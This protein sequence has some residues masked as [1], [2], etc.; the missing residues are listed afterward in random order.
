MLLPELCASPFDF[1]GDIIHSAA[2]CTESGEEC[3]RNLIRLN[4][5]VLAG[6]GSITA[7]LLTWLVF[8]ENIIH[9]CFLSLD[10]KTK[11]KDVLIPH[12]AYLNRRQSLH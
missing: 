1:S 8:A 10:C 3:R 7:N 11:E 6:S 9:R 2:A 5:S 4:H 12:S